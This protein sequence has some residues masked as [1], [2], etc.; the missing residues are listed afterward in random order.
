MLCLVALLFLPETPDVAANRG[1]ARAG[2]RPARLAGE[3]PLPIAAAAGATKTHCTAQA[4]RRVHAALAKAV[5]RNSATGRF[6]AMQHTL[7]VSPRREFC[8]PPWRTRSRA[9]DARSRYRPL[10]PARD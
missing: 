6:R 8:R 7:G 10:Q 9:H 3:M 4:S 5:R 1:A 2:R